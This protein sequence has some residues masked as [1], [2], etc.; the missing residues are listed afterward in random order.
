L[1]NYASRDVSTQVVGFDFFCRFTLYICDCGL[2]SR[3][4]VKISLQSVQLLSWESLDGI[5]VGF[6]A[7]RTDWL[8]DRQTDI[9]ADTH[10]HTLTEVIFT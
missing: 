7:V 5:Y 2:D 4:A 10:T 8:T 9:Q 6:A 3:S 1:K